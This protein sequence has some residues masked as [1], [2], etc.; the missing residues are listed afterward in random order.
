ML[1]L[2]MSQ[3]FQLLP[4]LLLAL[5]DH[6]SKGNCNRLAPPSWLL[7]IVS[8]IVLSSY[9]ACRVR[10]RCRRVHT[11]FEFEAPWVAFG[12]RCF[13][14]AAKLEG[15]NAISIVLKALRADFAVVQ[16]LVQ[17]TNRKTRL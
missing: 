2:L 3:S 11:I 15:D 5:L 13:H 10:K 14:V 9:A 16:V 12:T 8:E 17:R 6:P 7:R 1:L 4:N